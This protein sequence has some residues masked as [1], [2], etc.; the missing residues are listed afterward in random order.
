M[1]ARRLR[2]IVHPVLAPISSVIS[3]LTSLAAP[4]TS[5]SKRWA[6]NA[7]LRFLSTQDHPD[8]RSC[9]FADMANECSAM[10]ASGGEAGH[11]LRPLA[12]TIDEYR[13]RLTPSAGRVIRL[14]RPRARQRNLVERDGR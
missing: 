4:L 14:K 2:L 7:E 1:A 6:Q 5:R 3:F 11:S 8:F 9:H 12:Y 10:S 13:S